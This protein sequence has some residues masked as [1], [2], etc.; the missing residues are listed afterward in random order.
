[1]LSGMRVLVFQ[2]KKHT[3]FVIYPEDESLHENLYE[4]R[5]IFIHPYSLLSRTLTNFPLFG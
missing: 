5:A 1:M 4:Y 3:A 2:K